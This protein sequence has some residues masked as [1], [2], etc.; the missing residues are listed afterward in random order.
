MHTSVK[1]RIS[2]TMEI[3]HDN[4]NSIIEIV[5]AIEEYLNKDIDENNPNNYG[6]TN[7]HIN[8]LT[9]KS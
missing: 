6:V 5:R 3:E 4:S 8:G 7:I 9:I 1:T 2:V